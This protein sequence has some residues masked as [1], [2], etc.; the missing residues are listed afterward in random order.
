ML[1]LTQ[2]SYKAFYIGI[3]SVL[4]IEIRH[5]IRICDLIIHIDVYLKAFIVIGRVG[6]EIYAENK[7]RAQDGKYFFKVFFHVCSSSFL[8]HWGSDCCLFGAERDNSLPCASL[9]TDFSESKSGKILFVWLSVACF[10]RKREI[11]FK[12]QLCTDAFLRRKAVEKPFAAQTPPRKRGF[13]STHQT[14][15]GKTSK[16]LR[17]LSSS[18]AD[19][20]HCSMM[21]SV[22]ILTL[23]KARA[24]FYIVLQSTGH[25]FPTSSLSRDDYG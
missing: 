13:L 20:P 15:V 17:S 24:I 14:I 6:R 5:D 7:G 22:Q 9:F 21:G 3:C 12:V 25:T 1:Y 2:V 18:L 16:H 23:A 10:G 11:F 8:L 19:A 4:T